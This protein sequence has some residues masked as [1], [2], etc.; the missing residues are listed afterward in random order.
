MLENKVALVTGAGRGIGRAIAIALAKEGAEVVVNYNGSEERAKEVKQTI[1]ENGGKA[2]IYKCNVSDFEACE[3]MIK[4]IVKEHGRLDILVNNAGITKDGLIMKM[5]EEDFDSVLNVNLKGT[6]NTIRHSARQ[7]LRQ[8]SG[9]IINISSVSG[10][11]GNAGQANYAA[12]K[13]GVIG[14]TKTMARE[15][16]SR[17]ITVNAI[18][19]GFVDTEMTGVL[20][21]EIRENACRQIILG[22]FGKPE[23]IANVAVFLASDKADYI[24]GQVISVDG[25]MNV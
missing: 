16:G 7:M 18:A 13:A 17:G 1:E 23:D 8:K 25:G 14:L 3:A 24:T 19:P 20:S 6:F 5:K 12:S 10:I 22:R 15:L 11:L 4:D 2:S 9:K 21:E